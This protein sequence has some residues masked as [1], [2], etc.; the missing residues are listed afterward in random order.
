M[1]DIT[2]QVGNQAWFSHTSWVMEKH[3]HWAVVGQTGSGKTTWVKGLC[4]KLPLVSG[5]ILFYFDAEDPAKGRPY[6][7]PKEVA[8]LSAETHQDFLRPYAEYHQA[9]WQSFEGDE[10]P[11]PASL[12]ASLSPPPGRLA[13]I[14][15]WLQIEPILNRK[16]LH[17]S[18]GESRKVLIARLWLENPRLLIL[19]DPYTGLDRETRAHLEEAIGAMLRQGEPQVLFVTA[20]PAEIPAGI[21]N[22]LWIKDRQVAARGER[23]AVLAQVNAEPASSPGLPRFRK[24]GAFEGG[25]A[26]FSRALAQNPLLA[27]PEIIKMRS[28]SVSYAGIQVLR[29]VSWTV[30]PGERWA[31]QGRNG[32]GKSTLLS[33]I[34]ADNPQAYTNA[35]D[36]FGRRR[37][38]G[39]SIWEIKRNIGWVSPELHVYYPKTATCQDVVRSGFFDSAGLYHTC[40]PQQK[41]AATGWLQTFE[42]EALA[43]LPFARLSAGQQRQALLARALVKNP[44]LLILDEPCQ[45]LDDAHRRYFVDL[46]DQLCAH[47]PLTLIYVTHVEEELPAAITHRLRLERGRIVG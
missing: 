14:V 19:D 4:R 3:Q 15:S 10:A 35:I 17:L 44:P 36:L 45:G 46:L 27:C 7:L 23:E 39:E 5:Q 31:L 30:R 28:V 8:V 24:T 25:M 40:T 21:R 6:T 12:F 29:D 32:A 33:L 1:N 2:L 11:T 37:G 47:T 26:R 42:L 16:I 13:E 18:H 41:A 34:L 43:G 9:R 22:V 20:R 38:S